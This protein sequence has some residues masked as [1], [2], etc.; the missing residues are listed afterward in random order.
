MSVICK[1]WKENES[2]DWSE[3][4][5]FEPTEQFR[6]AAVEN[7]QSIIADSEEETVKMHKCEHKQWHFSSGF[8]SNILSCKDCA[9]WQFC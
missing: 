3:S 7:C 2:F 4:H 6:L 5:D 8:P 9:Y 1:F